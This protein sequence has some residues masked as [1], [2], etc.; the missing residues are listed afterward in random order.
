MDTHKFSMKTKRIIVLAI[1]VTIVVSSVSAGLLISNSGITETNGVGVLY[2]DDPGGITASAI[3]QDN[4]VGITASAIDDLLTLRLNN[5]TAP[6]APAITEVGADGFTYTGS[7]GIT[8]SGVNSLT[9]AQGSGITVRSANVLTITN[10]GGSSYQADS[11]FI[12]QGSGITA[13]DMGTL[14]LIG[15]KGVSGN[16]G[17]SRDIDYANGVTAFGV[18]GIM[19][20]SAN[21][22]IATDNN[23]QVFS[24]APSS[25]TISGATGISVTGSDDVRFN[26]AESLF[27]NGLLNNTPIR[28]PRIQGV[29]PGLATLLDR[30]TNDSNVNAAVVY[31][32]AV[33]D[34][35]IATLRQIGVLLGQRYRV[36]PVVAVTATKRQ[37]L[38]ISQ[39]STVRSIYSNQT[40][41]LLAEP[42]NGLTGTTRVKTDAEL[43]AVNG[44]QSV[45]GRNVTV[46]VLDTGLDGT[47]ADL[48]GRV[49]RNAKLVGV[50]GLGV[51]FNYPL[52]V[53]GLPNTD[54]VSGHGTFVAGVIAGNGARSGGAYTGV[55]PGARL[56]G[57]STGD[58]TLLSVIEGFDYILW[59]QQE[60]NIKVVNCSFSGDTFYDPNNPVNVATKLLTDRGVS[61]V[62][63]AGNDGPGMDTLNPYAMAPWVISVGATDEVG[64]L[65]NF[66][67]RG[68][69]TKMSRPSLVAPGVN[70]IGPRATGVDLNGLLNL[71]LGGDLS[72]LNLLSLDPLFYTVGSG[73][74]FSAP[75][76]SGTIALMLDVNPSL[77]PA[78]IR[79]I[80]L[81]TATPLPPYY[82]YEVGAGML[83]AHAA[84]LEAAFSGRRMGMFRASL[85]SRQARFV[86]DP[87]RM[88][89]GTVPL[90]LLG[91]LGSYTANINIP[92]NS[93]LASV[94]V[95]WGPEL[96]I[97]D[98]SM[99]LFAP[100]GAAR[101]VVNTLNLP[102]LTGRRERD[103]IKNPAPGTWRVKLTHTLIG[104]PQDFTGTLETT[105]AEY[106]ALNDIG[107]LTAAQKADAYQNLR[108][109]VMATSGDR[110]R[111][112]FTISRFDLASALVVC[113]RVPQYLGGQ[114][115]YTDATDNATRI[116]VESVQSAP[117][118]PLFTDAS[119][120]GPFRPD[121]RATRLTAAIALVRA[122]GLRSEAESKAGI[123]L[124]VSDAYTIPSNLRGYV[125]VA[126]N[127]GLMSSD[128][129]V[130]RP[131]DALKRFELARAM[132][133]IT[134]LATQ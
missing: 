41:K 119:T 1:I 129:G 97:N 55:A 122:A 111:P 34:S 3:D 117:G 73:T 13:W 110:F 74:S 94:Q 54:L 107:G 12:H 124:S 16:E 60:L 100:N 53:E 22:I 56:V 47:H 58:L 123:S 15:L 6:T 33:T 105:H 46:A 44:G 88:F 113:G 38:Q 20:N 71:G 29:E 108:W 118:G 116:M 49:V 7:N 40:L 26:G 77:T 18:G 93:L 112:Q 115:R 87:L 90:G 79:D 68:S 45:I 106:P 70:V 28:P 114:P 52:T 42:G 31:H 51:N 103:L 14:K 17:G 69:F 32:Q 121:D 24:I 63:S 11:V 85:D 64:R 126:L 36:L 27:T 78:Q 101:P 43:T 92:Q 86:N 83:N 35:D 72:R 75:Q 67:S 89:S 81:R 98:L 127:R 10:S 2:R 48:S 134:N 82:R 131:N 19:L 57:V 130:F 4:P 133:G 30:L 9:I 95:A 23:G 84:V 21:G 37:I 120:G 62:F 91:L 39:L 66:S 80:L 25:I 76:V 8:A 59:K 132:V 109:F 102:I 99:Q 65:A 125:W 61:V 50:A 104:T 5:I 96:S 128:G